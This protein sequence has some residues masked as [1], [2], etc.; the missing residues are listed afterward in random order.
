MVKDQHV[1]ALFK[2]TKGDFTCEPLVCCLCL[3]EQ[4]VYDAIDS[5]VT[6]SYIV[7]FVHF[8]PKRRMF[9]AV[10]KCL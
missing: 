2:Y 4:L 8:Y 9:M 1:S 5:Q 10:K 6:F 3:H 7:H